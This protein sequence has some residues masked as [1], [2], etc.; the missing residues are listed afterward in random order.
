MPR[1]LMLGFTSK[2]YRASDSRERRNYQG[3]VKIV[4]E[5]NSNKE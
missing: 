3:E 5:N 1:A 2:V 4:S